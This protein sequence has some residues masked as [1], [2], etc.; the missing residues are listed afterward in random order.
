M[1]DTVDVRVSQLLANHYL[2]LANGSAHRF[3]SEPEDIDQGGSPKAID[4]IAARL[5]VVMD[6][7]S[8]ETCTLPI[9]GGKD[10]RL[11]AAA[12]TPEARERVAH[13][14]VYEINWI[15]QFDVASARMVAAHLGVPLEVKDVLSGACDAEL[16]GLD[17]DR[18]EA[19]AALATGYVD[20]RQAA[21]VSKAMLVTPGGGL[22]LRGG[23]AELVHA[24]KWPYAPRIPEVI[25]AGFGFERL[26]T[27]SSDAIRDTYGD[28][29]FERYLEK[30]AQWFDALPEGAKARAPDVAHRELWLSGPFGAV[31]YAPRKQFYLNPFNDNILMQLATRFRPGMRRH[32]HLLKALLNRLSPGLADV[33]YAVQLQVRAKQ[34]S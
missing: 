16:D 22:L 23:A 14:C 18:I 6:G 5:Q 20:P 27:K 3:R 34:A 4:Q 32:G 2:D 9:T 29:L 28:A 10:S 30:Y 11:L 19:Q 7:L 12:L 26:L 17:T 21:S 8:R 25:T 13:F 24:N 33:P 1:G 15:T 31:F